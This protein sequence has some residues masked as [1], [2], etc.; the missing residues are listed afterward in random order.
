[1]TERE[2]KIIGAT[3]RPQ[4]EIIAMMMLNRVARALD[5]FVDSLIVN[6]YRVEWHII[7]DWLEGQVKQIRMVKKDFKATE[8]DVELTQIALPF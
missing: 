4:R 5:D 6:E 3:F 1:M 8:K 2:D 7:E